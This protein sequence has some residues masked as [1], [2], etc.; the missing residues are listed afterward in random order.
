MTQT[1]AT[2]RVVLH[3]FGEKDFEAVSELMA[4]TSL[5]DFAARPAA[6]AAQVELCEYVAATTWLRVRAH[7]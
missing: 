2:R 6:V 5:T 4:E 7:V 1:D 3:P